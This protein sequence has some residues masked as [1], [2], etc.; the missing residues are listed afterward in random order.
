MG[1]TGWEILQSPDREVSLE[2][3]SHVRRGAQGNITYSTPVGDPIPTR[4]YL[5]PGDVVGGGGGCG[6]GGGGGGGW[7]VVTV[8]VRT[9]P[10]SLSQAPTQKTNFPNLFQ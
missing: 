2:H 7:H 1:G 8:T 6:G 10:P 9:R 4:P 5:L 3:R